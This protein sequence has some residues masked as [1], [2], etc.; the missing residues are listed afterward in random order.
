[1]PSI[2]GFSES[3]PENWSKE[4]E[5]LLQKTIRDLGVKLEGSWLE[6]LVERLYSE[7]EAAGLRFKPRVYLSNEWSCPDGIPIIGIP[8]YLADKKLSR[9]EEEMMEGI[10]AETEEEV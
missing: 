5:A 8:F 7:L 9:L 1:M 2:G 3:S 4:R 10:E 6:K